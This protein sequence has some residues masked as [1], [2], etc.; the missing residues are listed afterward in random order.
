MGRHPEFPKLFIFN[1]LGT[2]G[3][4]MAPTL[5]REFANYL[6]GGKKISKEISVERF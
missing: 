4:T 3:Y 5:S 2:K 1:G 6:M